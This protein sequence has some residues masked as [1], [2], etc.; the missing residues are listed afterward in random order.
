[1]ARPAVGPRWKSKFARFVQAYGVARLAKGLDV[2][3][4]AI[5]HWIRGRTG[6]RRCLAAII[7]RLARE[8]GARLTYE[9]IYQHAE[10]LL[11][12]KPESGT[13]QRLHLVERAPQSSDD[14]RA[15]PASNPPSMK[16][17]VNRGLHEPARANR[18]RRDSQKV[19][20][21]RPSSRTRARNEAV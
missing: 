19:G 15:N 8:S 9:Q 4:I 3:P 16:P 5:Y 1:M 20:S 13:E 2:T 7:L 10:D 17:I 12:A 6:P 18:G 11:D 21:T 14:P